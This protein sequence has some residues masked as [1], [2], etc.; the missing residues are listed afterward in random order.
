MPGGAGRRPRC[1]IGRPGSR[2]NS[3]RYNDLGASGIYKSWPLA[4]EA[5]EQRRVLSLVDVVGRFHDEIAVV[6]V[7]ADGPSVEEALVAEQPEGDPVVEQE[8]DF[9]FPAQ[10]FKRR[11]FE[12]HGRGYSGPLLPEEADS[13][14][15]IARVVRELDAQKVACPSGEN[16]SGR[17]GIDERLPLRRVR[18]GGQAYD[19]GWPQYRFAGTYESFFLA[20]REGVSGLVH[21]T[22]TMYDSAAGR[23][24][25]ITVRSRRRWSMS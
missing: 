7:H 2:C 14:V 21:P 20:P 25:S 12:L 5:V 10:V 18:P 11:E 23:T 16:G 22:P 24:Y 19:Q 15:R 6:S 4:V 9:G 17:A 3:E 1:A 8:V 13:L